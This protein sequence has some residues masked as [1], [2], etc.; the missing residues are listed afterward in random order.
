MAIGSGPAA[1]QEM[2][3]NRM[4][5]T[6]TSLAVLVVNLI[7]LGLGPTLVALL[8]DYVFADPKQLHTALAITTPCMALVAAVFGRLSLKPYASSRLYLARYLREQA[9]AGPS[10]L[11]PAAAQAAH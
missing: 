11:V 9:H 7:G 1:L 8:T 6:T 3:P 10:E 2:L 4:R 5:G